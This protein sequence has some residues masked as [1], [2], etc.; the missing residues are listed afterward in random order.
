MAQP[1]LGRLE[2]VPLREVWKSESGDFTPWLA[3]EG[4]LRLLGET[5]G[6]DLELEKQEQ[7]VGAFR[8]DLLCKNTLDD[9]WVLIENQIE[10]TD[11]THL[12]QILTYAAGLEAVTVIWVA[13][14]F[15]DEHR[16]ALDWLNEI[17]EEKFTF[18]GL[19]VE[20]W[21]IGD[22]NP[23]PKFNIVSKPNDWSRTVQKAAGA[24]GELSPHKQLQLR[25]WTA[26]KEHMEAKGS[27]V[28][29]QKPLAQHWM[30]HALGRSGFHLDSIVSLWSSETG[31][32]GPEIRTELYVDGPSAKRQFAALESQK[33]AIEGALGFSLTWHNPEGKLACRAFARRDAD[34]LDESLWLEQFEWLRQRLE[35]M[36]AVL[37]PI[38]RDLKVDESD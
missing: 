6:L 33:A 17:T 5:V 37:R 29:C 9:S 3:Q 26:F 21:R 34:F 38:V 4:N 30:N 24:S 19:E 27:P 15:T 35:K 36:Y 16:A 28:R 10:R 8:A 32:K 7:E 25:F 14:T 12:G 11:H 1:N 2:R 31:V 20:L 13:E 18:F 23:A 22:S